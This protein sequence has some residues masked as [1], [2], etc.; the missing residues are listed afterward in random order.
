MLDLDRPQYGT[1]RG[2]EPGVPPRPRRG[3][4]RRPR[5]TFMAKLLSDPELNRFDELQKKQA[6]FSITA[7]EAD[8]LR[9]IVVRAQHKRESRAAA[10]STIEAHIAEFDISAEELFSREQIADAARAFGLLSQVKKEK[11]SGPAVVFNGKTH[12]WTRNLPDDVRD[13]LFGAFQAGASIQAFVAARQDSA[14]LAELVA[15][16]ERETATASSES[17]LGELGLAREAVDK[18][19]EKVAFAV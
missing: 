11:P 5:T 6:N 7:A 9:D 8:E 10:M 12:V 2:R 14:K 3:F 18:L 15:R 4:L 17:I 13:A 16:L 19:K 1:R